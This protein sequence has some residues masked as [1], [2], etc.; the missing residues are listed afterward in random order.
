MHNLQRH[1][2]NWF[3]APQTDGGEL[4]FC[5][6]STDPDSGASAT[7]LVLANDAGSWRGFE[8]RRPE[9]GLPGDA[10]GRVDL[11]DYLN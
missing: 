2:V 1:G 9:G 3:E 6:V 10:S 4:W 8:L 7:Y 11:V 5:K